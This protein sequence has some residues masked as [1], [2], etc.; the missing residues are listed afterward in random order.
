MYATSVKTSVSMKLL[1]MYPFRHIYT[2][3]PTS[4][5]PEQRPNTFMYTL[6]T[7]T[8]QSMRTQVRVFKVPYSHRSGID[9]LVGGMSVVSNKPLAEIRVVFGYFVPPV[10]ASG[11]AEYRA[12]MF[13]AVR[14]ELSQGELS[15][16]HRASV[17]DVQCMLMSKAVENAWDS[18]C[19]D[20]VNFQELVNF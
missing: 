3:S 20:I 1:T 8:L 9:R 6:T 16:I 7:G 10:L 15:F 18:V 17:E 11:I 12:V 14:F 13:H 5:V 2:S 4:H 19:R